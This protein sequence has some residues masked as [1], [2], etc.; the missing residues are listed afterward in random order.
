AE[1]AAFGGLT[2]NGGHVRRDTA[3]RRAEQRV[4]HL[5]ELDR[6]LGH[7]PCEAL[8]GT[9]VEWHA[10]PAPVVDE[11]AHRD[12]RL[13]ARILRDVAFL[14][15][16]GHFFALHE[17]TGVLPAHDVLLDERTLHRTERAQDLHLLVAHRVGR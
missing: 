6:D 5:L 14:A 12:E 10:A 2:A 13:G 3:V 16:R 7:A 8:S 11:A 1:R 4:R 17:P 9:H 15:I